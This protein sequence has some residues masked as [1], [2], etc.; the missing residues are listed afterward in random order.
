ML[1]PIRRLSTIGINYYTNQFA[2]KR[3]KKWLALAEIVIWFVRIRTSA[4]ILISE[5]S[6][7][8]SNS[9][10]WDGEESR[11]GSST[12]QRCLSSGTG[13]PLFASVGRYWET[14]DLIKQVKMC[15]FLTLKAAIVGN[16][17]LMIQWL[18]FE[19]NNWSFNANQ[20][21]KLSIRESFD[22]PIHSLFAFLP[23]KVFHEI[24][25]QTI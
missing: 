3:T 6:E 24:W 17:F 12:L 19:S 20:S 22:S 4:N 5:Y 7:S 15:P 1:V 9:F 13:G 23:K 25:T 14:S 16:C 10:G 21:N 8:I 2:K 11:S 18:R